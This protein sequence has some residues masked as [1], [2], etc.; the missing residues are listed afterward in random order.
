MGEIAVRRLLLCTGLL[1]RDDTLLLVRC[2]YDGEPEPLWVLPGG[3]QEP[4][5]TIQQ[6]VTREFSE[7]TG[8]DVSLTEL[9]YVSESIDTQG[10]LHVLNCTFW[11]REPDAA[12]T[13]APRDPRVVEATFVPVSRAPALLRA[14]VLR[15]PVA[16]ALTGGAYPRYHL[17]NAAEVEI[18]F[19]GA[20]AARGKR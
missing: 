6:T 2:R 4:A 20:D 12:Q 19:F 8:L 3:R 10:A 7:E 16:Q 17:F 15:I 18:P 5:E 14:D 11:V 9:A 1:R 13:L